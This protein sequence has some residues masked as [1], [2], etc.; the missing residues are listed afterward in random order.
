MQKRNHQIKVM[1]NDEEKEKLDE[2]TEEH[3][4]KAET[5]RKCLNE[6]GIKEVERTEADKRI[7]YAPLT[8]LDG[9]KILKLSQ[10]WKASKSRVVAILV[11][12]ALS[13]NQK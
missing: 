13:K 1:L 6:K 7:M 2:V 5:L 9:E 8:T 11:N 3:L 4:S 12:R 10:K